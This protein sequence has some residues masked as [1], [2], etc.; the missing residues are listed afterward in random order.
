MLRNVLLSFAIGSM[1]CGGSQPTTESSSTQASASS[2][3]STNDVEG[4]DDRGSKPR[5]TADAGEFQVSDTDKLSRPNQA[6]L[7]PTASQAAVRF[8]V[9]DKDDGPVKGIVIGLSSPSGQK[10]YANETDADGF[11]EVLLPIGKT[12][13][14]VF[15]SLGRRD[16]T[17]KL[18]VANKP[19]LNLKL[20]LRYKREKY[21]I[22][23]VL[24][25][26]NF[27]TGKALLTQD[28][29]RRLDPVVEYMK[30]KQSVRI[31]IEGHTDNL[32][33]KK[34]NKRLSQKRAEAVR[35]YLV[36]KGIDGSRIEA[37]GY[38][39]SKPIAPNDTPE[40]RRTNRRIEAKE[41]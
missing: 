37:V 25:Q 40:G 19:S 31:R 10:F 16:I 12:Y 28:S 39:D 23:L 22:G 26:V 34:A 2:A 33:G 3:D 24:E 11:T 7:K 35:A 30:Y 9:I 36:S 8:F 15:L 41:L 5:K 17:A 18:K 21:P 4:P 27:T 1:A 14:L 38:G 13:E 32:G 20:T 6:K 29:H